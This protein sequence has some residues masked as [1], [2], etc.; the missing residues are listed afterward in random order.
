MLE[1][2]LQIE[3]YRIFTYGRRNDNRLIFIL[4]TF[5]EKKDKEVVWVYMWAHT[6]FGP[7]I[8]NDRLHNAVLPFL[9]HFG[10]FTSYKKYI[11]IY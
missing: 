10:V 6:L 7:G 4:T 8:S 2:I 3:Y 1:Y 5:V 11:L 9:P